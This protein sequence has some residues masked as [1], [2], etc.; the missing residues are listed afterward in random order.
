MRIRGSVAAFA[1]SM[2]AVGA[3]AVAV[4]VL[5]R[6]R[7]RTRAAA[8]NSTAGRSGDGRLPTLWDVPRFAFA[9]R[10]G[11]VI[12]QTTLRGEVWIADF[13][14]TRCVTL[15]PVTTAKLNVLRR[16]LAPTDV[17]FVSFSV[18]PEHDTPEILEAYARK[19]N[20]DSR[21]LLLRPPAAEVNEFARRM[22]AP[23]EHTAMPL[24][25]IL[26]TS[27]LFLVDRR[28]RVRGLYASLDDAAVLRLVADATKLAA[29][30]DAPATASA[31]PDGKQPPLP[32]V[33]R[34]RAM[35]QALGCGACHSDP[36]TGPSLVGLAGR[37]VRLEGGGTVLADDA[38]L[39][40]SILAPAR[41]VVSGYNPLMPAYGS[42]LR[43]A[44]VDAVVAYLQTG[45]AGTPPTVR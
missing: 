15:C 4:A 38:Y 7:S 39:R 26:H 22:N 16:L 8:S 27:M 14:F 40:Q 31:Q 19:W 18:D 41:Q 30:G 20:A 2:A 11:R 36:R 21:W 45:L 35:F 1:V 28:G 5:A 9:N 37:R 24:E 23:F 12:D 25:P 44:D 34:G 6:S 43:D 10:D 29:V 32:P 13:I 17:G 42:F 3:V 33:V